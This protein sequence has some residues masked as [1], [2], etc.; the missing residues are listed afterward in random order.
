MYSIIV[1]LRLSGSL[2]KAE[3][4]L[5]E[6][7]PVVKDSLAK[8]IKE[9]NLTLQDFYD[10][11]KKGQHDSKTKEFSNCIYQALEL[12]NDKGIINI[13]KA[14]DYIRHEYGDKAEDIIKHCLNQKDTP[15]ETSFGVRLCISNIVN[16]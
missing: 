3:P 6:T 2:V 11:I 10:S 13:N 15:V 7:D 14:T 8:C 5:T 1:L 16:N 4:S 9:Y 12:I